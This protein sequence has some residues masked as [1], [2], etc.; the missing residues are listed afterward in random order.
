MWRLLKRT[1]STILPKGDYLFDKVKDLEK[2]APY[3]MPKLE[4]KWKIVCVGFTLKELIYVK[5]NINIP[6]DVEALFYVTQDVVVR[7]SE[8]FPQVLGKDKTNKEIYQELIKNLPKLITDS[9]AY[10]LYNKFQGNIQRIEESIVELIDA[11]AGSPM[12]EAKHV[13][14]VSIVNNN[15]Y[16]KDV[17]YTYLLHNDV[18]IPK[19]GHTYSRY[20]WKKP[21]EMY[22]KLIDSI[23]VKYAFY[24]IRKQISNIVDGKIDYMKNKEC[25]AITSYVDIMWLSELYGS[26]LL[27]KWECLPILMENILRREKDDS[28]FKGKSIILTT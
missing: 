2:I 17:L 9:A 4:G 8:R 27:Y 6:E 3:L 23:G 16:A 26:F 11:S 22:N 15:V 25:D 13:D 21:E 19:K 24:A 7:F 10:S 20:K 12:I 18:T 28:I 1:R 14:A 5:E